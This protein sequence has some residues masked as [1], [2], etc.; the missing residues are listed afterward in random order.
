MLR[1]CLLK[2]SEG[3]LLAV[4]P[5]SKNQRSKIYTIDSDVARKRLRSDG[6]RGASAKPN[7]NQRQL[8]DLQLDHFCHRRGTLFRSASTP[9]LAPITQT[10]L[11]APKKGG[12][13]AIFD[14]FV[15]LWI[16]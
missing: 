13:G 2:G 16:G 11:A 5:T 14:R 1:I 7:S 8:W 10:A 9:H 6:K 4:V 12:V 3:R 15:A